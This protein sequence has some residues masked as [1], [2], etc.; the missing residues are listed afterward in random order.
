MPL[1]DTQKILAV[2]LFTSSN[3]CIHDSV[4]EGVI[5]IDCLD[6]IL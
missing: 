5:A 1:N 3:I 6:N 4:V 2:T